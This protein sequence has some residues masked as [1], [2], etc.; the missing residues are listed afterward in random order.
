MSR[1]AIEHDAAD[2]GETLSAVIL[3]LWDDLEQTLVASPAA[4]LT[5]VPVRASGVSAQRRE[6]VDV[7]PTRVRYAFD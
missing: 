7:K 4:S 1:L 2:A 5:A 6:E 3:R